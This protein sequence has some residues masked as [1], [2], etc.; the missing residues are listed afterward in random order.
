MGRGRTPCCD[1]TGLKKGPW[2]PAEDMKLIAF[3]QRHGHENWRALPKQ[4]GLLRCG[5]SCRLRWTNYLRPDIKR[6]NFT[7]EEEEIIIKLH[8]LLG[9]KWSKIAS[10]LPG[11]TDNEIKNVWNTHL[12]KRLVPKA[13]KILEE[14]VEKQ[15]PPVEV[16]PTE[17]KKDVLDALLDDKIGIEIENRMVQEV[18]RSRDECQKLSPSTSSS[19]CGSCVS[20]SNQIDASGREGQAYPQSESGGRLCETQS[21]LQEV[22][23]NEQT[24]ERL[25]IPF[26]PNLDF[27][28]VF[29]DYPC[30]LTSSVPMCGVESNQHSEG[31]KKEV[32]SMRWVSYLENELGLHETT[33]EVF[34]PQVSN[35]S[36]EEIL[37]K[38]EVDPVATYF[39]MSPSSPLN[40]GL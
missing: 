18:D 19:S 10:H 16:S 5:K 1:K 14:L 40:F 6:G 26:E 33:E 30:L 29:D 28:E 39:Q 34:Q 2:T 35:S 22:N 9:N 32:E 23:K 37:L 21:T 4:A 11:R 36:C 12:K 8:E 7:V 25:E 38:T 17:W 31:C 24:E 15:G 13:P 20:D 27:W 3:I